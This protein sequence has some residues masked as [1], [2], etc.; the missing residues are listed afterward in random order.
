MD[1]GHS[2]QLDGHHRRS[3]RTR[4]P[5]DC[6]RGRRHV[7][8]ILTFFAQRFERSIVNMFVVPAGMMFGPPVS[9]RTWVLWNQV[10]VTSATLC[11]ER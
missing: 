5:L 9:I 8:P 7:L 6:R 10:P 2:P 4:I 1:W 3:A 11:P